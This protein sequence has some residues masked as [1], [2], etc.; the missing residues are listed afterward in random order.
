VVLKSSV[1]SRWSF[2]GIG[3]VILYAVEKVVLVWV[4][5]KGAIAGGISTLR[6]WTECEMWNRG[7]VYGEMLINVSR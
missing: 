2:F 3:A 1:R 7:N 6:V 5:E 4:L